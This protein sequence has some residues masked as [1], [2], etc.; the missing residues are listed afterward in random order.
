MPKSPRNEKRERDF[1]AALEAREIADCAES[2]EY[3]VFRWAKTFD[4]HDKLNPVKNFPDKQY[5]RYLAKEFQHGP[6]IQ[7]IAKSR[8]LMVSWLLAAR[9]VWEILY[10]P[11]AW[12]V[13]QSKKLE[14]AAEMIY[15]TVPSKARASFIMAHL[16]PWMQVCICVDGEKRITKPFSLDQKTFSYG[17]I[18][19][20]NGSRAE[21]LAQGPAQIEGKVPSF[22]CSDESS[23]QEEWQQ[24]WAAAMPCIA[25]GGKAIAVATMRL[26]SAYGEE[27]APCDDVDPDGEFRGVARFKT[28]RGGEGIR[29]HYSADPEKDPR[30]P[31][32]AK[33]FVEETA[34]MDGGYDGSDWQQHMEINPQSIAGTRAIPY[35]ATIAS[36]VVVDDIPYEVASLWVLTSGLDYGARNKT[37]WTVRARDYEGNSYLVHELAIPAN[38]TQGI[39]GFAAL[40]KQSAYFNRVNGKIAADPSIW[41]EDQNTTSG[42]VSKAKLFEQ[43]GVRLVPAKAKGQVADEVLLNRLHGY[44]WAG[45]DEPGFVP[46]LFICR[47][48]RETIGGLP[49]LMY[50]D[51]KGVAFDTN[52]LV[53][54]LVDRKNDWW[55]SLK[56]DE[57]SNISATSRSAPRDKP[58]SF[59]WFLKVAKKEAN[60]S[61]YARS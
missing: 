26:P 34:K 6:D 24:S 45:Y 50:Q 47:S 4:P 10:H 21:A 57:V 61:K 56:Y 13:F 19:L 25:G 53:E 48:C 7:Y 38:E 40:M 12:A 9:T 11:H 16:P 37:V 33:W 54:K 18:I 49:K 60:L 41:N 31:E 23:L 28:K 3:F 43:A 14:D 20:P 42:I 27:I 39:T 17:S 52:S 5:L 36:Q 58:F 29:V 2:F 55:D 44:Y 35:W 8:Q 51:R 22:L 1:L 32:G 15:D 46:R 59:D 30:T